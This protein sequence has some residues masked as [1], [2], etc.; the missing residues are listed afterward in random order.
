MIVMVLIL[1]KKI[2]F[3]EHKFCSIFL[4]YQKKLD[5]AGVKTKLVLVKNVI[6]AFFALPGKIFNN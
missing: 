6:H 5:Q 3:N 4:E 2:K 1:K